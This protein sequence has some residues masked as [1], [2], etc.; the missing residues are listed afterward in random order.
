MIPVRSDSDTGGGWGE[1]QDRGISGRVGEERRGDGRSKVGRGTSGKE[2]GGKM[3]GGGRWGR[4]EGELE[5][6]GR[7]KKEGEIDCVDEEHGKRKS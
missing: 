1:G 7:R 2:G 3:V 4:K 5:G 6:S